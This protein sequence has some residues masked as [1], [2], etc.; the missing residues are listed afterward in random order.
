MK[1]I[2][3]ITFLIICGIAFTLFKAFNV[4]REVKVEW[5]SVSE[6][7]IERTVSERGVIAASNISLVQTTTS[8]SILFLRKNGEKVKKGDV[9]ARIDTSNYDDDIAEIA[10]ELKG[11]ELDL[12]F[13]KKKAEL[14]E[15]NYRNR[16]SEYKKK[17]EHAILEK[18]YEFD[19]PDKE[20]MRKLEI[21]FELKKLDLEEA[22]ANLKR[23]MNL[24]NKGFLSKASLEPYER[25]FETA[26]EKVKEAKLDIE[27]AK[28]GIT[29]ERRVELEQN[30]LRSKADLERA[31]KRMMR[32]LGEIADIIKV[33]EQKIAELLHRKDNLMYKLSHSTCYASQDGYFKIRKYYDFRSG[34][35][36]SQYAAGVGIRERDVIGEVV[37][38]GEMRVDVIFNESDFHRLKTGLKVEISL[39][40]Y[41]ESKF[42]GQ[43]NRLGAIGKDRNLWLEELSGTSGVS[44]YNAEIN[45]EAKGVYLH[46][47]MSA[48]V[49]I[50]LEE[51]SKGLVIP[52]K[53]LI[54]EGGKFYAMTNASDKVELEGRYID[55]FS[56]EISS[57]LKSGD[58]VKVVYQEGT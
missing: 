36:Y 5:I 21:Q 23:Q 47:G 7:I 32:K 54:E 55:E 16:T 57:G 4:N 26:K 33:S 48:M 6:E 34:G 22:D 53:A 37:D 51:P 29:K 8:G 49:K 2:L 14:M 58:K 38:P 50:F 39:P 13:N 10:L 28:K 52:R 44:M 18:E 46:P 40:A 30:V 1:K 31:E 45:F 9:V 24:Y 42:A 3:F 43:L 12:N 15:K 17:Y 41:S 35:Q 20:E 27:I 25:R 11:E 19:K 56:F